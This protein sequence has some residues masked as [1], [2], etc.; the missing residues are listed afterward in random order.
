MK[1]Q[2]RDRMSR[3]HTRGYQAGLEGKSREACPY[4]VTD[5]REHWIGGWRE[6]RMSLG[7][8]NLL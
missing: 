6:A 5:V 4:A 3:A 2:K 7:G 8:E 1:R